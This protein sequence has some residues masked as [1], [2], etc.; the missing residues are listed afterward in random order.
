MTITK[1]IE[2]FCDYWRDDLKMI[3][4]LTVRTIT[5][6]QTDQ[7]RHKTVFSKKVLL[8]TVLDTLAG[9]RY[10]KERY[11][12]LNKKNQERFIKFCTNSEIWPEGNLVSVPFLEE[13]TKTG[14][15]AK[16][17][18]LSKFIEDRMITREDSLNILVKSIDEPLEKLLALAT[19]EEETKAIRENRHYELLYRYR[20]YLV[21]ESIEPGS[22]MEVVPEDDPFYHLYADGPKLYLAYPIGMFKQILE[23]AVQY[24]ECYLK[25]NNFDPYASVNETAR[26]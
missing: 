11:P 7:E 18:R 17:G 21:H 8:I 16:A 5:S 4:A 12:Q 23:R 14:K 9:V 10:P 2:F 26:W 19:T 25:A 13:H 15:I 6:Q 3:D 24:I 1:K 20:N 22:A